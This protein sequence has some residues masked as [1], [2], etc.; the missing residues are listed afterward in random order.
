MRLVSINMDLIAE[1]NVL[2]IEQANQISMFHDCILCQYETFSSL[3]IRINSTK[4]T[5]WR[6]YIENI[7]ARWS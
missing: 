5:L 2:H 1:L 3:F 6:I 4:K 7:I